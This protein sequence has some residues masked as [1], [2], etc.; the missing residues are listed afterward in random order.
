MFANYLDRLP[1]KSIIYTQ[2][3]TMTE[4]KSFNTIAILLFFELDNPISVCSQ[5]LD[6]VNLLVLYL[7]ANKDNTIIHNLM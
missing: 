1:T 3:L 7:Y 4:D 6:A 5:T 2:F